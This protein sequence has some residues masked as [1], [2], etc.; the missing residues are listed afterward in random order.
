MSVGHPIAQVNV[1]GPKTHPAVIETTRGY[2]REKIFGPTRRPSLYQR[3]MY[4]PSHGAMLAYMRAW[5]MFC[6]HRWH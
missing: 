1:P 4:F 3:A 5:D 2:C 6:E